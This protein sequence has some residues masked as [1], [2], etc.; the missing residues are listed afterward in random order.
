MAEDTEA[1]RVTSYDAISV[2]LTRD[3]VVTW[4]SG[5]DGRVKARVLTALMKAAPKAEQ[6]DVSAPTAPAVSAS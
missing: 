2:R 3:R 6:F 5:E 1:V 4:G